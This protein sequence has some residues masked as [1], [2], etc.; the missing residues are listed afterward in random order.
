VYAGT[1]PREDL[2]V[3]LESNNES[4]QRKILITIFI[5][6]EFFGVVP[7]APHGLLEAP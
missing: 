7:Q 3:T 5:V 4:I 2:D 1:V 6:E